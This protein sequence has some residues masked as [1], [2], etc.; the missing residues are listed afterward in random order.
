MVKHLPANARDMGSIPGV[1]RSHKPQLLKPTCLELMLHK[2]G[3]GSEKPKLSKKDP[4]QPK[5]N[6]IN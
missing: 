4:T 2:R 3:H 1:G 5:I 6:S